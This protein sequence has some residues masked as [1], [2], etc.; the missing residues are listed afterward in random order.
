MPARPFANALTLTLLLVVGSAH[1]QSSI[2]YF[3]VVDGDD[4]GAVSLL[5]FQEWMSRAFHKMDGNHDRVLDPDEQLIPNAPR[6]SFEELQQRLAVQFDRQDRDH[7]G[8]LSAAEYLAPP[9]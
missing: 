8:R 2:D 4:D 7:D 6:I 3:Q 1:A 9:Q 5:E